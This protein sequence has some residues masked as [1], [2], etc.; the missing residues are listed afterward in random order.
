MTVNEIMSFLESKGSEQTRKIY[1]KHGAPDGFY[2]VKV[3]DLKIIVK[4]VK[5]NH[6]LALDLF[7]TGNSDAMYLAGLIADSSQFTEETFLNWAKN[8]GWYMIAEYSVAWNLAESSLCMDICMKWIDSEDAFLQETAWAALGCRLSLIPNG[9]I[10]L[11][12]QMN[13]LNRVEET[14]HS[15]LNRT[16][17][18]MNGF[19]IA[20]GAAIPELTNRCKEVGDRIGKVNVT[21]GDTSCKVPMIRTYIE[22]VEARGSVGKKKKKLKC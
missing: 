1:S 18:C 19:V 17:Y 11:G 20:L 9:S 16:K 7:E 22:K 13:L 14:I 21:M 4:K 8:A 10:D 5:K 2:G 12:I 6:A 3:S 15:S